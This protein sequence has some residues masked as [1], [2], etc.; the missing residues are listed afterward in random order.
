M[1]SE[2]IS[3]VA[4]YL[5]GLLIILAIFLPGLYLTLDYSEKIEKILIKKNTPKWVVST[6]T[7]FFGFGGVLIFA[8]LGAMT[9]DYLGL[10]MHIFGD[11]I[12]YVMNL[13]RDFL[14]ILSSFFY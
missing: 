6:L 4:V 9:V 11:P 10:D 3:K 7:S 1:L 12:G 8:F 14:H 2:I 13:L 5:V